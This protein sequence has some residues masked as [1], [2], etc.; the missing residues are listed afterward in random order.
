MNL[1]GYSDK[2]LGLR[3][4][5]AMLHA[6]LLTANQHFVHLDPVVRVELISAIAGQLVA[7]RR[8]K[9]GRNLCR[10]VHAVSKRVSP[11]WRWNCIAD[12]PG[13]NVATSHA[14]W[15]QTVSGSFVRAN[16]VPA[17]TLTL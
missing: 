8:E 7:V 17:V 11:T 13:F 10:I 14:A 2:R 1:Y 9:P 15:N 12:I 16:D 3:T 5:T 4:A 6:L